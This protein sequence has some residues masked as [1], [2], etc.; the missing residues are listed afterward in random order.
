[1]TLCC[2]C[3]QSFSYD[4]T[5]A[6]EVFECAWCQRPITMP[7]LESLPAS[8]REEYEE[9]IA[10]RA[11]KRRQRDE[12]ERARVRREAEEQ[13]RREADRARRKQEAEERARAERQREERLR[14]QEILRQSARRDSSAIPAVTTPPENQEGIR[15]EAHSS[16]E[17][18]S[19]ASILIIWVSGVLL[20]VAIVSIFG[21]GGKGG[22]DIE[23]WMLVMRAV[24]SFMSLAILL[25]FIFAALRLLRVIRQNTR[26]KSDKS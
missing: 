6:G 11:E 17:K 14:Q 16:A 22:L 24:A 5:R 12:K 23:V 2:A 9:E 3:G 13:A 15:R 26:Q 8:D 19:T 25:G 4:H 18:V 10:Q 7:A 21:M 20:I 1:M